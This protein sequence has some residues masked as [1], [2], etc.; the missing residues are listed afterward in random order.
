M[1]KFLISTIVVTLV[2]TL[3]GVFV[4]C[5]DNNSNNDAETAQKAITAVRSLYLDKAEETPEDYKVNGT[6][7]VG[8]TVYNIKWSVSSDFQ[9]YKNYITVGKMDAD[10]KVTIGITKA[11]EEISY[12]LKATVTVGKA[13]KSAEFN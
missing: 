4:A 1:K 10:K 11:T 9:D 5:G 12:K 2:A 8:S 6:Q 3:M 7:K 13:S